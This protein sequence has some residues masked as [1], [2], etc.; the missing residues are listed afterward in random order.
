MRGSWVVQKEPDLH[1]EQHLAY[2]VL[3]SVLLAV[4]EEKENETAIGSCVGGTPGL[5]RECFRRY[6]IDFVTIRDAGNTADST[7]YG[8]VG[9]C[10]FTSFGSLERSL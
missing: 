2:R 5:C 4:F 6:D 1:L 7:G 9:T 8:A 10:R 3:G